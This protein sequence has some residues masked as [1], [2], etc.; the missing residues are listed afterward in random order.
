MSQGLRQDR[1]KAIHGGLSGPT[2]RLNAI[3]PI[4]DRLGLEG[5]VLWIEHPA[6][7]VLRDPLR[8][9]LD[10]SIDEQRQFAIDGLVGNRSIPPLELPKTL[11]C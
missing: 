11:V 9:L 2:C 4:V 8:I 6:V 3:S 1:C 5:R 10:A 7:S